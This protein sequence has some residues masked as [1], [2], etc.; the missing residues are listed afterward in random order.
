MRKFD[1]FWVQK[2]YTERA[3][4]ILT[5]R[6]FF[7]NNIYYGSLSKKYLSRKKNGP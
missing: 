7:K 4:A 5:V 2:L 6:T 3:H 1:L